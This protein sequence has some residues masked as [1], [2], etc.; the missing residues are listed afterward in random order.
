MWFSRVGPE[1][2]KKPPGFR[3]WRF[4]RGFGLSL[5]G[6]VRQQAGKVEEETE[7][8]AL[9]G[10]GLKHTGQPFGKWGVSNVTPV[11]SSR[12]ES[13][14]QGRQTATHGKRT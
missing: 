14:T 12:N 8:P 2:K 3:R 5:A 13:D 6:S 1:A 4:Y 9:H 10:E 11:A 7:E